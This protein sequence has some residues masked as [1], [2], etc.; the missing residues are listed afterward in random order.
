MNLVYFLHSS[1]LTWNIF[2]NLLFLSGLP[3]PIIVSGRR[4]NVQSLP[5]VTGKH[6]LFQCCLMLVLVIGHKTDKKLIKIS[7]TYVSIFTRL[8][9]IFEDLWWIWPW[10]LWSKTHIQPIFS[11]PRENGPSF[12]MVQDSQDCAR[13]KGPINFFTVG[14]SVPEGIKWPVVLQNSFNRELSF[15]CD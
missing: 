12:L 2:V 3:N 8:F 13:V 9:S 10:F 7:K 1:T 15:L 4:A 14:R 6:R 5:A 11:F